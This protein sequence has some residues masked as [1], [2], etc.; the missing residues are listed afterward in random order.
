MTLTRGTCLAIIAA[1]A[2]GVTVQNAKAR[3]FRLQSEA[4][5]EAYFLGQSQDGHALAK[6]FDKYVHDFPCPD[7]GPCV[8]S[9]ELETPYMQVVETTR[10]HVNNYSALDAEKDYAARPPTVTLNVQ[11]TFAPNY[12]TPTTI[13]TADGD[14]AAGS[15]DTYFYGFQ[16][17]VTQRGKALHPKKVSEQYSDI[18]D[19]GGTGCEGCVNENRVFLEFDP[20][21]IHSGL[22]DIDITSPEGKTVSAEYDLDQLK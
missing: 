10:T 19:A 9:I 13:Y 16:F 18:G 20:T 21:Q 17:H 3:T 22:L 1:G 4:I 6:F 15:G 8:A 2:L 5:R 12:S 14:A 7:S 11:V